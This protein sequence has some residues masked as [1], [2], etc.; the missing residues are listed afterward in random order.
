M[1]IFFIFLRKKKLFIF[2]KIYLKFFKFTWKIQN[3]LNRKKNQISDFTDF[4][5]SSY[6]HFSVILW[7]H[8][9]KFQRNFTITRKLI[10]GNFFGGFSNL[11][12][13]KR[14]IKDHKIKTALFERG[15]G[16]ADR[17]LGN[18]RLYIL[19][20]H[21]TFLKDKTTAVWNILADHTWDC[22][23]FLVAS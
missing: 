14:I 22:V 1:N 8:H 3:R 18:S 10:I 7:R 21:G 19:N 5:F 20:A 6:G 12:K 11:L 9:P 16:F 23:N 4:Y 13:T 15:G 2:K 17:Y